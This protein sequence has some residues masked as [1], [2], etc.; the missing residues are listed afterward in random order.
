MVLKSARLPGRCNKIF[1]VITM[2][3]T[4]WTI[5]V[6]IFRNTVIL[7][8]LGIAIGIP[9]GIVALVIGFASGKS[10]YTL[11]G[12]G[13]IAALMFF[14]WIFIMAFYRGKYEA[15]FI[16]DDKGVIC[17]TQAAQVKKNRGV[18]ALTVVLGLMSGKPSVAGAGMLAQAR[19]EVFL[20]WKQ[21]R[22]VKYKPNSHTILLRGGAT[23]NIALFCTEANYAQVEQEVMEQTKHLLKESSSVHTH[24]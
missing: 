19:Q 20:R 17:R 15:E 16:V 13:M 18:N 24:E 2:Q 22:K 4:H 12:L 7:K 6:P 10:V 23:E 21:V 3:T 5:S 9:F 8:Q 14:S 11:Y 1:G